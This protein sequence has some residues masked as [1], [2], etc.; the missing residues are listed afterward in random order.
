MSAD[1]SKRLENVEFALT[2]L[3]KAYDELNLVVFSQQK[4]IDLLRQALSK[5][6]SSLQSLQESDRVPRS[7]EDDRP[8]HY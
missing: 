5:L 7:L 2:H 4:E 3:Q 1:E 6:N 8:P